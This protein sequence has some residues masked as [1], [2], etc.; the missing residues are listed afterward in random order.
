MKKTRAVSWCEGRIKQL[1]DYI[2]K[3]LYK[4]VENNFDQYEA[5]KIITEITSYS[6]RSYYDNYINI[7]NITK[8]RVYLHNL[9]ED[10][11]KAVE[12]VNRLRHFQNQLSR[13]VSY[14]SEAEKLL[15]AD[16][17][18]YFRGILAAVAGTQGD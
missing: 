11:Q 1:E 16:N 4:Y 10:V 13:N 7:C 9:S 8:G 18:E 15:F 6:L 3:E 17:G 14:Q 12:I 5:E 2:T